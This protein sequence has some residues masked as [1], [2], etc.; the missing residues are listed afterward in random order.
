[1]GASFWVTHGKTFWVLYVCLASPEAG[2]GNGGNEERP[3]NPKNALDCHD[4]QRATR[5]RP[6]RAIVCIHARVHVTLLCLT[7]GRP[8]GRLAFRA[9]GSAHW[10]LSSAILRI[11]VL[12]TTPLRPGWLLGIYAP[13]GPPMNGRLPAGVIV[14]SPCIVN[15]SHSLPY[16]N[17]NQA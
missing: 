6:D 8:D 1:M 15:K 3:D 12:D 2:P 13:R 7:P 5:P 4:G 17:P 10:A 16:A 14:A 9:S 11:S